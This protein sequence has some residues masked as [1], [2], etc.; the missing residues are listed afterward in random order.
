MNRNLQQTS[1]EQSANRAAAYASADVALGSSDEPA[2]GAHLIT[3]R[4]G[5]EHH[6]IYVGRGKVIH[7]AGFAKSAHRGP[8]EEVALEQFADGHAVAVRP[9][10]FPKYS[11]EETVLRARSRIGENHYR[12]LTNNC[13]HFCAWCLLGE[14]RSEQ[15]HACL[16]HPRTGFHALLCLVSAFVANRMKTGFGVVNAA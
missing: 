13:E 16:T 1:S 2:L 11:G 7:Y 6:G 9:H 5:Y 14:S 3:Q 12:L 15:V 8:V 4:R 10:P